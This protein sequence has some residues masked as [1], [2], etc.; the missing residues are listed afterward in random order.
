MGTVNRDHSSGI[1]SG[2][3]LG[4]IAG[5][6]VCFGFVV[7]EI[8]APASTAPS[9]MPFFQEYLPQLASTFSN[10]MTLPPLYAIGGAVGSMLAGI[11]A[12]MAIGVA[13]GASTD[14]YRNRQRP[15]EKALN[16]ELPGFDVQF[17]KS[18]GLARQAK[19]KFYR[20]FNLNRTTGE[21]NVELGRIETET[22]C[23]PLSTGMILPT[24]NNV[25]KMD[26]NIPYSA[27]NQEERSVVDA[28][29]KH[30]YVNPRDPSPANRLLIKKN[31]SDPSHMSS[32]MSE[33]NQ[34]SVNTHSSNG[35]PAGINNFYRKSGFNSSP[36]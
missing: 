30:L 13:V 26:R 8:F 31:L 18:Y 7:P 17:D 36:K 2:L 25:E 14:S 29:A 28:M 15:D 12:P 21:A 5:I 4:S 3:F 6:A 33:E 19:N 1:I 11:L 32:H 16:D 20:R 10:I 22:S 34:A 23:I 27:M 35:N 9:L 24:S